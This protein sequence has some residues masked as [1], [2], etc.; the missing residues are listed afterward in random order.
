MKESG[1]HSDSEYY[2]WTSTGTDTEDESGNKDDDWGPAGES[3]VEEDTT[4]DE[5][6]MSEDQ[7][8]IK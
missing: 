8:Y 4:E 2:T 1:N 7:N 6:E 3:N 5:A